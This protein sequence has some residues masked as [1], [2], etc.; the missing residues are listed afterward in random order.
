LFTIVLSA[1]LAFAGE[2][3]EYDAQGRLIKVTYGDGMSISYTYDN[4]GNIVSTVVEGNSAPGP[5][6]RLQPEDSTIVRADPVRFAWSKAVDPN[7]D[8]VTYS[9]NI[10]VSRVDTSFTTQDTS[11]VVDFG[12][13]VSSTEAFEVT[14]TVQASDG[15]LTSRPS[16]EEGFFVLDLTT[17]VEEPRA[18]LPTDFALYPNY[19]NPFNPETTIRYDLPVRAE[20]RLTIYDLLGR[21]VRT[22]V[23][24]TQSAGAHS[25]V[26]DGRDDAGRQLASGVYVYRLEAGAFKQSAK[27]LL[28]K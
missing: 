18:G 9:L 2:T 20:V 11:L 4:T 27:M 5:F 8:S 28:M 15:Q 13:L 26:W 3:Y 7:D 14:W 24:Q 25:A 23:A 12:E 21:T 6:S 22:L 17:S 16:N 1:S 10:V 19:P